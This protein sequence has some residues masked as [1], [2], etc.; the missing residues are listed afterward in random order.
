M[1]RSEKIKLS[2]EAGKLEKEADT[3]DAGD[4]DAARREWGQVRKAARE[5]YLANQDWR[6]ILTAYRERD[7]FYTPPEREKMVKE[8]TDELIMNANR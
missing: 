7:G 4:R 6:V 3:R 2:Q 1:K 8:Y 5:A